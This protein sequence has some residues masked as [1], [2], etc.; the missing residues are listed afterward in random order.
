MPNALEQAK[1]C[2]S[3]IAGR[4]RPPAETPWFWSDQYDIKLQIA[5]LPLEV[6][7]VVVRG[8]P[9]DGRF[10]VF[11]LAADDRVMAVEAVN[12]A[13]EFMGGR[14]LIGAQKRVAPDRL[15]D[16]SLTMKALA[17]G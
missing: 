11:H 6:A 9:E 8:A 3:A 7:E 14:Q 12:A 15:R 16:M 13:P 17:T 2:A 5:G 1:A 4:P 10:A